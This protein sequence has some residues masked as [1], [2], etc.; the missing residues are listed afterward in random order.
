MKKALPVMQNSSGAYALH[1]YLQDELLNK[2]SLG[3]LIWLLDCGR[4]LEFSYNGSLGFISC[5][6]TKKAISLW[7]DKKEYAFD[8]VSSLLEAKC[9]A[10][11]CLLEIWDAIEIETL[12]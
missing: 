1:Q 7:L 5:S 6:E 2:K 9:F 11:K 4:E 10:D 3:A 8:S 12:F